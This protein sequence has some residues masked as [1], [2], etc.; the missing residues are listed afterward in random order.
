MRWLNDMSIRFCF[1]ETNFCFF[2]S[3]ILPFDFLLVYLQWI[4]L[5]II[6]LSV[7]ICPSMVF[8]SIGALC[9]ACWRRFLNNNL[10]YLVISF[11]YRF[12]SKGWPQ[13]A[14]SWTKD[15]LWFVRH[16]GFWDLVKCEYYFLSYNK[17]FNS[18]A[19]NPMK[20]SWANTSKS[21]ES[22]LSSS[23]FAPQI[24]KIAVTIR[25][26]FFSGINPY[27]I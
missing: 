27:F 13:V 24:T 12:T 10:L 23:S 19:A 9:W 7:Q 4:R 5:I 18:F 3:I 6:F 14:F 26:I 17:P 21:W 22:I 16:S 25:K 11:L 2:R 15:Y 8:L 20:K 1:L